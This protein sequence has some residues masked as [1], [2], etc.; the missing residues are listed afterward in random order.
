MEESII[1]IET[2]K[3]GKLS[4]FPTPCVTPECVNCAHA[5]TRRGVYPYYMCALEEGIRHS[6]YVCE[7]FTPSEN[8]IWLAWE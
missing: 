5:A 3:F 1:T 7:N 6:R 2:L 8:A 4:E